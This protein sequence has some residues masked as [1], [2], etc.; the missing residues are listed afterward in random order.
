MGDALDCEALA[1]DI[2]LAYRDA[3][4]AEVAELRAELDHILA[5]ASVP[6]AS[7]EALERWERGWGEILARVKRDGVTETSLAPQYFRHT[8]MRLAGRY[9]RAESTDFEPKLYRA[10][11]DRL[12]RD[13]LGEAEH[14]VEIGCGTGLNLLQL[15]ELYPDARLTGA[16]WA[17]PSQ[18]L[19][20]MIPGVAGV[21]FDMRTLEAGDS[22]GIDDLTAVLTLHAMEQL[23]GDF[24]PL[25]DFLVVS[26]PHI[27]LHLEPVAELYDP[28]DPF[29]AAA[30]AYHHKR[31]YLSG[32]L[33]ALRRRLDVKIEQVQRLRFGSP[34]HEAYSLIMWR[35]I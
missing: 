34:F 30:L 31:G 33:T 21:R 10:I 20:A 19:V 23:G 24:G 26:Q 11:K 18:E 12:F 8:T 17:R 29:D 28:G 25:L 32:Y 7:A 3:T 13:Y 14:I 15:R 1:R 5:D 9:I 35:P 16:D 6:R 4:S 22:L 27:V 2:G